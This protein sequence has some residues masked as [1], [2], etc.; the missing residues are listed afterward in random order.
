MYPLDNFQDVSQN[1]F[2]TP[3]TMNNV[4]Q[5][6]MNNVPQEQFQSKPITKED[7]MVVENLLAESHSNNNN[8]QNNLVFEKFNYVPEVPATNQGV[9]MT[10]MAMPGLPAQ[11]TTQVQT[12]PHA[13]TQATI[14]PQAAV[15]SQVAAVAQPLTQ[16]QTEN[17][18][19]FTNQLENQDEGEDSK[20]RSLVET[21][22]FVC[23]ISFALIINDVSKYYINRSINQGQATHKFFLY[24]LAL[25]GF[26]SVLFT[27]LLDRF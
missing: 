15:Q 16:S 6:T 1:Y 24:Y 22:K 9:S 25:M 13:Q 21:L 12:Q 2:N 10:G 20:Y 5:E 17:K 18:A 26:L 8:P 7:M 4:R 23:I 27:K 11:A 14:P 19:H 3:E